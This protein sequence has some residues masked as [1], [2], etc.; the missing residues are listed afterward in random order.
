[1]T[2]SVVVLPGE[3]IGPEVIAEA[4]KVMEWFVKTQKL[5]LQLDIES[6]GFSCYKE[7]GVLVTADTLSKIA[8]SKAVLF[9]ATGGPEF[10]AI[11]E[12]VRSKGNLLAL[13]RRM[14]VYANLRPIVAY[15]ELE[16]VSPIKNEVARG[17]DIIIVRELNGGIYFGEPRG[18]AV[19][20]M[21]ADQSVNTLIYSAGEIERVARVAFQLAG[22]RN[23]VVHSVDKSNVL[24]TYRLWRD[25]VNRIGG[26][27]FP[28]IELNHILVDNCA[29]QIIRD[30][31][32]FDV[33]LADN[34]IGDI[35]SDLAGALT[36]SLGMLPSASLNQFVTG[37]TGRSLYE[38]V[39]G[40]AP[41]IAGKGTANPIGAILSVGLMMEYSLGKRDLNQL[42][43]KAVS[44]VLR[45]RVR[46]P[47]IA[48]RETG[49]VSTAEMGK[50]IVAALERFH[51]GL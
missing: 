4:V 25:V 39:H 24:E 45:S 47:D 9:G 23:G 6:Y 42:L 10:D 36:G 28:G 34:M 12:E 5:D 35:L 38:P 33:I 41:D 26:D 18:D 20:G 51:K 22:K 27:E 1:V 30:P 21:A 40:S 8:A 19:D 48:S 3:G 32:Q 37:S 14:S 15:R 31:R 43:Q 16:D 46:T 17:A 13:R 29:L 50:E 7:S 2:D 44:K 49:S 11:P